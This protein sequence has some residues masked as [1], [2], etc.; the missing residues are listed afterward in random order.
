MDLADVRIFCK[1]VMPWQE[2]MAVATEVMAPGLV[3]RLIDNEQTRIV[4][5]NEEPSKASATRV[6]SRT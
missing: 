4:V 5:T 3:D 2:S 6:L 1:C